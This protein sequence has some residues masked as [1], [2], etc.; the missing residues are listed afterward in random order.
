M[1]GCWL[2]GFYG[3]PREAERSAGSGGQR[4]ADPVVAWAPGL[5][6]DLGA[7]DL[8]AAGG[9]DSQVWASDE[10]GL[11]DGRVAAGSR[12]RAGEIEGVAVGAAVGP[13]KSDGERGRCA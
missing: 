5:R 8:A 6:G 1:G 12:A 7:C 10:G 3:E 9:G 11:A 2:S 13:P 4:H